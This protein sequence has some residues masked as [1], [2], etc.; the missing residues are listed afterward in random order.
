MSTAMLLPVGAVLMLRGL[1]L[2]ETM[3]WL[4]NS[5]H[6]A[7]LFA[8]LVLMLYR[9]EHYTSGY[10]FLRW[11]AAPPS[12]GSFEALAPQEQGIGN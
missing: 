2:S 4:A 5:Q 1:G 7:M 3:A 8:M 6:A 11:Q 12:R 10:S 9:R